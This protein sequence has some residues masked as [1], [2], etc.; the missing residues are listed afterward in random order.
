MARFSVLYGGV[1][2]GSP[3]CEVEDARTGRRWQFLDIDRW[4]CVVAGANGMRRAEGLG[5]A[6]TL[7]VVNLVLYEAKRMASSLAT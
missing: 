5:L 1:L 4:E 6:E 2:F 7:Q 3:S